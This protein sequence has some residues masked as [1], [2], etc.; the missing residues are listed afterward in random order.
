MDNIVSDSFSEDL[1]LACGEGKSLHIWNW[2]ALIVPSEK[3]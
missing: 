3:K 2:I 1:G